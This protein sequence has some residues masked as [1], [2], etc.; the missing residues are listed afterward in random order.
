MNDDLFTS[1]SLTSKA[2]KTSSTYFMKLNELIDED[3]DRVFCFVEGV[4]DMKYYY[5][6]IL[7]ICQKE[8]REIICN[9]KENV[10]IAHAEISTR[11]E[12]SRYA[13][14]YFVDADFDDNTNLSKDICYTEG[15]AIEN[16]YG[17]DDTV[18]NMLRTAYCLNSKKALLGELLEMYKIEKE[19]FLTHTLLFNAWYAALH[20]MEEWKNGWRISLDDHFPN[21]LGKCEIGCG[22]YGEYAM[23]NIVTL[24]DGAPSIPSELI[25]SQKERIVANKDLLVR[26]KYVMQVLCYFI[27]YINDGSGKIH[28]PYFSKW[29]H[30]IEPCAESILTSMSQ[31]AYT[32]KSLMDY[33]KT[34][35]RI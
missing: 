28:K 10:I 34:G 27:Q 21:E 20:Q 8:P 5:G 31:F 14:R 4:N 25:D 9:G 6:R 15:Y 13:I 32:P 35:K 22:K 33:I 11:P 30:K 16:Y 2:E 1:D 19:K 3:N 7:Y 24:Y 12:M 17:L 29:K 18:S 26:G 23:E